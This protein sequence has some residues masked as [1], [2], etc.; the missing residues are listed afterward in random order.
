MFELIVACLDQGESVK[1]G[2]G[3]ESQMRRPRRAYGCSSGS[4]G[5]FQR[6]EMIHTYKDELTT[7]QE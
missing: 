5:K 1:M 7:E 3:S 2:T 6:W 4:S